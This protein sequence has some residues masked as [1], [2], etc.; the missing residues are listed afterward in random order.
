MTIIIGGYIAVAMGCKYWSIRTSVSGHCLRI[1]FKICQTVAG[2]SKCDESI[3]QIL[4]YF[5]PDFNHR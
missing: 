1:I 5:L 2:I 3:S 4:D